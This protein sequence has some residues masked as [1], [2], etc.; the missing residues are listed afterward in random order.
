MLSY[1][2]CCLG[3]APASPFKLFT[4]VIPSW[5][6]TLL[7]TLG[8]YFV[9]AQLEKVKASA[10]RHQNF[11]VGE[12]DTTILVYK[13]FPFK[14]QN[15][16]NSQ[17]LQRKQK[18]LATCCSCS[19]DSLPPSASS[20]I[21]SNTPWALLAFLMTLSWAGQ[22]CSST[23]IEQRVRKDGQNQAHTCRRKKEGDSRRL[24]LARQT[25][26]LT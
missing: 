24:D 17:F 8:S 11:R 20:A 7:R 4:L 26:G 25:Q 19:L 2:R 14:A 22:R 13:Q 6:Q 23:G 21:P 1:W 15:P 5:F 9:S 10:I 3:R 12:A 18:F 16:I